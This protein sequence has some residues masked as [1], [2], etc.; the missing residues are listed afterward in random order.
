MFALR[1]LILALLVLTTTSRQFGRF[2]VGLAKNQPGRSSS[3]SQI[4][5]S[6]IGDKKLWTARRHRGRATA[7]NKHVIRGGAESTRGGS[8]VAVKTMTAGRMKMFK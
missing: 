6:A 2:G 5:A 1:G 4:P 3:S 7:A 8:S